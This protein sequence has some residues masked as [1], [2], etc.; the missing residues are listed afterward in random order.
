MA[1]YYLRGPGGVPDVRQ[2]VIL[3]GRE[4]GLRWRW[5]QRSSRWALDLSDATGALVVGGIGVVVNVPLLAPVRG[6][7]E[8][9]AFP[10]GELFV[11]DSRERPAP[12]TLEGLGSARWRIVYLD[13]AEL[14]T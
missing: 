10:P 11:H 5:L 9:S 8:A 13:A 3:D 4:W 14:A 12:P 7:R 1:A 6:G 2:R